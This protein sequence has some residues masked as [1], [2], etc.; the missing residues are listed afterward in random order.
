MGILSFAVGVIAL[1]VAVLLLKRYKKTPQTA[2]LYVAIANLSWSFVFL[3]ASLIYLLAGMDLALGQIL[4]V[5]MYDSIFA[6]VI[7]IY[8][9]ARKAFSTGKSRFDLFYIILG[10]MLAVIVAITASSYVEPFPDSVGGNYPAIILRTEHGLILFAY[11]VPTIVGIVI[12]AF[13]VASRLGDK[14]FARGFQVI[15]LGLICSLVTMVC[16]TIATLVIS[17][18]VGYALA[19]YAQWI[20]NLLATLFLYVGWTM[21]GWFQ[22]RYGVKADK[23]TST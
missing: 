1:Y 21:P 4:Q 8:M 13:R 16:D 14:L 7:F 22:R 12:L 2:T 20:F 5:M 15:G 6:T 9:F 11:V 19:L 17:D 18:A 3:F 23:L 10:L